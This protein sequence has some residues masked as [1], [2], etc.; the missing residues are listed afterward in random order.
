M[1][2]LRVGLMTLRK[3]DNLLVQVQEAGMLKE[4]QLGV[5]KNPWG[6]VQGT[7]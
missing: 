6:K 3:W 1:S 7:P 5:S 4:V 2:L